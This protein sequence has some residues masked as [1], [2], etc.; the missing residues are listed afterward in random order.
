M[1]GA[2]GGIGEALFAQLSAD[3]RFGHTLALSRSSTPP[4][5]L[6]DEASI[7]LAAAHVASLATPLRLVMV[8]TGFLHGGGFQPEKA[9]RQ[10][11]PEHLR[12]AFALNV[13]GPALV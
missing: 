10:L 5:D 4:L 1:V 2:R 6:Q 7:A 8:A 11:D 3:T 9:L 13:I 12:T